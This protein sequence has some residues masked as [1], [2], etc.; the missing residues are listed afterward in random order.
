MSRKTPETDLKDQVC[1]KLDKMQS[2]GYAIIYWRRNADG[3]NF[4][5][6]DPDIYG[7]FNG[8]HFEIELK[9]KDGELS[10]SQKRVIERFKRFKINYI[11]LDKI[12]NLEPFLLKIAHIE[13]N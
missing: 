2:S 5:Q 4:H 10:S 13:K 11:L 3:I 12:D 8:Y 9:A 7:S 1:K 6:G